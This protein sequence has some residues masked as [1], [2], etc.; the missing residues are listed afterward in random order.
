MR[1]I[2]TT[3]FEFSEL[4]EQAK[5]K[6][7]DWYR[8]AGM[9]DEWWDGVYETATDAGSI[10]GIEIDDIYFSGFCSQGDGARFMGRYGYAKG[11]AKAIR[12]EF[13]QDAELHAIAD[14]LQ[15]VQARNF[16][17]LHARMS[18]NGRYEH[19]G[20]MAVETDDSYLYDVAYRYVS[21][22]DEG[23]ITRI[24]RAFADWI[25]S[26]L[27]QEYD[28]LNSDEQVD[29]SILVNEY[30]FDKDGEPA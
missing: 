25:Y 30:E 11:G 19:S 23:E 15:V 14:S 20:C 1:T 21:E 3:I 9:H 10:L 2:E 28:W 12:G 18:G 26:L 24:M 29:E 4:S 7:R 8:S 6:A 17:Q 27:S 16:Y 22:D 13:P 5:E